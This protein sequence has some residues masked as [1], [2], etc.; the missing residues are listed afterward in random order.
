MSRHD[1]EIAA[2]LDDDFELFP[3]LPD[4]RDYP[5]D[6]KTRAIQASVPRAAL[7][8]DSGCRRGCPEGE[9]YCAEPIWAETA[10]TCIGCGS[11]DGACYC[12]EE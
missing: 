12:G 3:A 1:E 9:C 7:L 8:N 11:M 5:D 6:L 2:D 10:L 4:P